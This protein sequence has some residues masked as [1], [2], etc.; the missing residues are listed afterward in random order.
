MTFADTDRLAQLIAAKL[1]VVELLLGLA[2]RQLAL[3]DQGD[4]PALLK[5]LSAKQTVIAQ[6]QRLEREL[7]AYRDQDPDSRVW[8]TA[9]D[10]RRCQE[11]AA[12][13][14]T[15]L[16]EA[17]SLDRQGEAAMVQRRDSAAAALQLAHSAADAH[18]AYRSPAANSPVATVLQCEG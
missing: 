18:S 16:T 9:A 1:Q 6:L 14:A 15:L 5:L 10:R 4:I 3:A 17:M 2:R 12:R 7:D 11:Q 8:Q 13:C